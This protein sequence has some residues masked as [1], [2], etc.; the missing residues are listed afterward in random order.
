MLGSSLAVAG[1]LL[2]AASSLGSQV[3]SSA[4]GYYMQKKMMEQQYEYKLKEAKNLPRAQIQGLRNAN[5]NPLLAVGGSFGGSPSALSGGGVSSG[6][7]D[8][9][10]GAQRGAMMGSAVGASIKENEKKKKENQILDEKLRQE[11]SLT[12]ALQAESQTRETQAYL[13][14]IEANAQI[15]ALTGKVPYVDVDGQ[16]SPYRSQQFKDYVKKLRNQIEY[17][18]YKRNYNHAVWEDTINAV[19]GIHEGASAYESVQG[20]RKQYKKGN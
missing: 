10:S 1:G 13:N 5:M 7:V 4:L 8:Y 17:D 19:H 18:S 11:E 9:L 15:G 2:G 3:G 6:T 12:S 16:P 20:S 14:E